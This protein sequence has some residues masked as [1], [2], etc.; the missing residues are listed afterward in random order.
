[1]KRLA[2]CTVIRLVS[3]RLIGCNKR[4]DGKQPEQTPPARRATIEQRN[5]AKERLIIYIC[6]VSE[7][8]IQAKI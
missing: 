6:M 3:S 7:D 2:S 5:R 8:G 1:M 4:N